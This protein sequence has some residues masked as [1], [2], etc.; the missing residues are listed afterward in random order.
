MSASKA[1][2]APSELPGSADAGATTWRLITNARAQK[3]M[4]ECDIDQSGS[5]D[6]SELLPCFGTWKQLAEAH[7]AEAAQNSPACCVIA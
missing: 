7:T 1:P 6:R 2:S 4:R 3:I 5:I